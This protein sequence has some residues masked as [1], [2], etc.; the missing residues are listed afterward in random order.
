MSSRCRNGLNSLAMHLIGHMKISQF[1]RL[2]VQ[3]S[4]FFIF[5][6]KDKVSSYGW[7]RDIFDWLFA[8]FFLFFLFTF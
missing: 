1:L 8:S 5:A 4:R 7:M 6:H 2:W 3:S